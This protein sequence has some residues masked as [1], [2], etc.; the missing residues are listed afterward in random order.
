MHIE[1]YLVY[2]F[3]WL[4]AFCLHAFYVGDAEFVAKWKPDNDDHH[5]QLNYFIITVAQKM[6]VANKNGSKAGDANHATLQ[7]CILID[8]DK[9]AYFLE[10]V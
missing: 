1:A 4:C 7:K 8:L 6:L 5:H 10:A 3:F 9:F 2:A